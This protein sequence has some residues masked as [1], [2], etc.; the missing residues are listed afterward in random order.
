MRLTTRGRYAVMALVDLAQ[1]A[2]SQP[3]ALSEV[4]RR[5][6]ISLSYLEQLFSRLRRA[7]LVNGVRGPGGGYSLARPPDD[8]RIS[9]VM[10]AVD[11]PMRATR[12]MPGSPEGCRQNRA[13]CSTHDLWEELGRQVQI[14]LGSL[15]IADVC[16]RRVMGTAGVAN[17]GGRHKST[18]R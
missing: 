6:D 15:T 4:A 7:G 18:T 2:D 9:D 8:M 11:E 5:Q 13:R 17:I 10:L 16:E 14:F 3:L 1:N 12:C